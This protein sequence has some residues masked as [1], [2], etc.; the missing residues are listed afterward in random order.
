M[1][2]LDLTLSQDEK[3]TN[4]QLLYLVS[5]FLFHFQVFLEPTYLAV[6]LPANVV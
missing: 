5:S 6:S 2:P 1:V 4:F 3:K